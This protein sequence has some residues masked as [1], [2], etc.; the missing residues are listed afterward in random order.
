MC[1]L[2]QLII[3]LNQFK[4]SFSVFFSF[5]L[6]LS[7][8]IPLLIVS[9]DV[10][11]HAHTLTIVRPVRVLARGGITSRLPAVHVVAVI[12]HTLGVMWHVRVLAVGDRFFGAAASSVWLLFGSG[13]GFFCGLTLIIFK[14]L[15]SGSLSRTLDSGIWFVCG[16]I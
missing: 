6:A 8:V 2:P 11:I 9:V 16:R 15:N 1:D 10:A 3:L 4:L 7:T 12:A 5:G 13:F 14:P